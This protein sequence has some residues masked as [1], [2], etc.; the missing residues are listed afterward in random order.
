MVRPWLLRRPQMGQY[1]RLMNELLMED[2]THYKNFVRMQ[3]A[4]F[5]ELLAKVG[6]GI[7]KQDTFW[8][9]AL[10]PGLRIAI[11]LRYLATGNS[12]KSL[13][14]GFRVAHNTIS[15]IIPEVCEAIIMIIAEYAEDV[16]SCPTTPEEWREVA[17]L[18]E[19]R[20]N[21][22]HCIGAIDGKHLAIRCPP[23]GGSL[24]CNYSMAHMELSIC[25]RNAGS[26]P[27][28]RIVA[29]RCA[30]PP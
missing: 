16:I 23:K 27:L 14:Y 30:Y 18:L 17:Q 15:N 12:Y 5:Q 2:G 1:E 11:T 13:M 22:P 20:L 26:Q 8:R 9:K 7:T 25:R 21:F 6:P 24:Y 3:P 29:G 28:S 10:E 4:M 19:T